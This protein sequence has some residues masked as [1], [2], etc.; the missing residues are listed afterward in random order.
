M[1]FVCY[2]V[3]STLVPGV[4]KLEQSHLLS[5]VRLERMIDCE[6]PY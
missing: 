6:Y 4:L 1:A 5:G 2:N 3:K